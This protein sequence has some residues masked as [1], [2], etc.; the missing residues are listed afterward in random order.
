MYILL[1]GVAESN[2]E[3]CHM[4][5]HLKMSARNLQKAV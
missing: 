3:L 5:Q 1:S 2:Y 4:H